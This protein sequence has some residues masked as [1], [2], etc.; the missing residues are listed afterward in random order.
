MNERE[1]RWKELEE[2]IICPLTLKPCSEVGRLRRRE[3]W[4]SRSAVIYT[5]ECPRYNIRVSG[6]GE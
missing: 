3:E 2:E 6:W 5:L 1:Q 4:I